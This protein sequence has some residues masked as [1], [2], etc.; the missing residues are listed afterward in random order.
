M[1]D[2]MGLSLTEKRILLAQLLREKAAQEQARFPL[3]HGQRGLWFLHQLQ[4][5]S[6]AYNVAFA[7]RIRSPLDLPAFRRALQLL[8]DRHPSLRTTFEESAGQLFQRVHESIV[9]PF[10]VIDASALGEAQLQERLADEAHRPFDLER[11]PLVRIHLFCRSADDHVLLLN[12]HH[13]VGDLWSL[14]VVFDEMRQVYPL[15][16]EGRS[17]ALPPLAAHYRDFV[18]WQADLLAGADGERLAGYWQRKLAGVPTALDL[19]TDRPRPARLRHHGGALPCRLGP[20]LIARV[21][22]LATR[23]QVTVYTVLL[24]AFQ[25]ML[26]RYTGQ[27]DFV[28]GSPFAGRSRPEFERLVGYFI[29][30]V[31]LRADLAGDPPF[32]ELLARTSATVLE[33]LAHQDFPFPLLVQRLGVPRDPSRTPLFQAAFALE[34]VRPAGQMDALRFLAPQNGTPVHVAGL[35]TE[36]CSVEPRTCQTDLDLILEEG[37]GTIEGLLHY[38]TDLFD[39]D[40]VERL[41]THYLNLLEGAVAD[42]DRRLSELPLLSETERCQ[43]LCDWNQTRAD[44]PTDLCLHDLVEQQAQRTPDAVAVALDEQTLTCAELELRANEVAEELRQRGIGRGQLVALLCERS[45]AMIVA[46]LGVLKAG[47]AYVPLDPASPRRR[48][49]LILSD[50]RTPL[51]LTQAH[52]AKKFGAAGDRLSGQDD[53]VAL[54]PAD[55]STSRPADAR[56]SPA[57]GLPTGDDLAYVIYT[58][59]STGPPRGVMVEHRAIV[60]TIHWHLLVQELR[61]SDRVLLTLP[62]HFDASLCAIFPTLAA[63][64]RLVL[65]RPGEERD[66]YQLLQ[67][68][69][70]EKVTVLHTLPSLLRLLLDC[71]VLDAARDPLATLRWVGCGGEVLPPDLP[72]RLFDRCDARLFNLYGPTEVAVDA[73]AWECR[74]GESRPVIP[75]GRPIANVQLYVLD[76]QRRPVPIG[77]PGELYV[78]GAGLAR[79]YLNDARL[80]AERFLP[81]ADCGVELAKTALGRPAR[82]YRTGDRGRWRPDGTLEFLGRLDQQVKIR[83]HRVEVG[84]IESALMDH[85]A[86]REAA[87]AL[88]PEPDGDDRLV[89]YLVANDNGTDPGKPDLPLESLR[90]HLRQRLPD[91][92]IPAA[93]VPLAALPRT[94]SGKV[95]RKALPAVNRQ[96]ARARPFV[97]PRTAL[98]EF[99]AG[100]YRV[101][102]RLEQVGIDDNFFELGGD[103]LQAAVL[104][105]RVQ[106]KL[107]QHV[108]TIAIF[109]AP[110]VAGLARHLAEAFPRALADCGLESADGTR[111]SMEVDPA[112]CDPGPAIRNDLLVPLQPLGSRPPL[113]LVHPPGGIVVCYQ[114]LARHLGI[115]QPV[116]AIRSR[117]LHGEEALPDR[118]EDMA[119]EYVAAV[120]RQQP[121]GPYHLGGW[122]MG[123]VVA[124]EM[125]RQLLALGQPIGLLAFLDTTIPCGPA[126][127][128][129]LEEADRTGKEYGLDMSLEELERLDA[130]KQLPYLYDH[131]QK[132]GLVELDMPVEIVRQIIDDLKR[133]FH[134]HVKLAAG[135]ALQPYP[136]RITLFRPSEMPFLVPTRRDRGWGQLALEVEVHFVPGHHHTMVKDPYVQV[137]A[138]KLRACLPP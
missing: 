132:L 32:R 79:G 66:P 55:V 33:A 49:D 30:M 112:S 89:A 37:H 135:Y 47:A 130:E 136:G 19:P 40:T 70:R 51:L 91:Y 65:A 97:P 113:F 31:P 59:G 74:R 8:I 96:P 107:G 10:E 26:G 102:L 128:R 73:A 94:P 13:I 48:L 121:D 14:A 46:V 127:D 5:Q 71:P 87:V 86:V 101:L 39:R 15:L 57:R 114:P 41:V 21:K 85:P 99:L 108:S 45:P 131:V 20:E 110:T 68:I 36:P 84:E 12:V 7:V 56:R 4:P 24:S 18:R 42:P 88:R 2:P 1:I 95:D 25:A 133:L 103:S 83:G 34:K 98:E 81:L 82:L 109:D 90:Q 44:F 72:G 52:L 106:E 28:I 123:G 22:A 76:P 134:H 29:N 23:A 53:L 122:S 27:E 129:F 92:M 3:A 35:K 125:A 104:I 100:L 54:V 111:Q 63:G 6:A 67:R 105:N 60:N 80:T 17:A 69:A 115:G 64:A 9:L 124:L 43:V 75:I 126:N 137:L 119:A 78:G 11:G 61:E 138:E 62:Y 16:R 116:Y 58:S 38:R 118:L 120:R 50:T 93:F 117:G 77:V